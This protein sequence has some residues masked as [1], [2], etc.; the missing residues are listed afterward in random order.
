MKN[1]YLIKEGTVVLVEGKNDSTNE[2]D[3]LR[4]KVR[5]KDDG[6]VNVSD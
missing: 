3:A 1:N 5:L 2:A 6:N 4:V